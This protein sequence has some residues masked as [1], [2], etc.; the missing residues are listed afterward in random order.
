MAQ[1]ITLQDCIN[2]RKAVLFDTN[3]LID[4]WRDRG[5]HPFL[6]VPPELR[7]IS[8]IN[9]FEFLV[10]RNFETADIFSHDERKRRERWLNNYSIKTLHLTKNSSIY[11]GRL[12]DSKVIIELED[13]L[14]AATAIAEN[15]ALA[16]RNFKHYKSIED[17]KFFLITDFLEANN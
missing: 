11:F 3:I 6:N 17:K 5:T 8:I 4:F 9:R 7:Y 12:F 16:T 2:Q 14:I 13:G 15:C 1:D 10:K